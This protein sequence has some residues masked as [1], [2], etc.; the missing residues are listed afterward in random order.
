MLK[1]SQMGLDWWE[2]FKTP[3]EVRK[4]EVNSMVFIDIL[5]KHKYDWY[6]GIARHNGVRGEFDL[7]IQ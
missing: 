2:F 1:E 3:C 6:G 7:P 4:L 5:E